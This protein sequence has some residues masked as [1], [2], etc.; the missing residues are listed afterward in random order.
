MGFIHDVSVEPGKTEPTKEANY[1]V[2]GFFRLNK[3]HLL[4][5]KESKNGK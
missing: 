5:I 4:M 1:I 3:K 2:P